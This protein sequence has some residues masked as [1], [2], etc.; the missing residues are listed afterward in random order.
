MKITVSGCNKKS[1]K[2]F[3][4][5]QEWNVLFSCVALLLRVE[6]IPLKSNVK[7]GK[8]VWAMRTNSV[9]AL[10]LLN[11]HHFILDGSAILLLKNQ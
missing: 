2:L 4:L 7:T 1:L 9:T 3:G 8:N 10:Q 6:P 11:L 5:N